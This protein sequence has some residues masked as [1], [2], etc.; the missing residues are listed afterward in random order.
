M[1][2]TQKLT[3]QNT[4]NPQHPTKIHP[5][6]ERHILFRRRR[7]IPPLD[8]TIL[9]PGVVHDGYG[10]GEGFEGFG[11][12]FS[13]DRHVVALAIF[14]QQVQRGGWMEERKGR[15]REREERGRGRREE[16]ARSSDQDRIP[17]THTRRKP[18][19]HRNDEFLEVLSCFACVIRHC[20][21]LYSQSFISILFRFLPYLACSTC[22]PR[23]DEEWG[24]GE[25]SKG[26][27]QKN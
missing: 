15:E 17:C 9:E 24:G 25:G 5:M 7:Q 2:E 4:S 20:D 27:R 16:D 19:T 22:F 18:R 11:R 14:S 3:S 6:R 8:E 12:V 1:E 10:P 21:F 26:A 13:V 23:S